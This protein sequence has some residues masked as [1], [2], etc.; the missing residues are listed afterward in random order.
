MARQ[1][2][3]GDFCADDSSSRRPF[4]R[5]AAVAACMPVARRRSNR[6]NRLRLRMRLTTLFART[7]PM[8]D[9]ARERGPPAEYFRIGPPSRRY[10]ASRAE[11]I[12]LR[13]IFFSG[14]SRSVF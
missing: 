7:V 14:W 1:I 4:V 11:V 2:S 12:A 3:A 9:T 5:R 8:S 6:S 10:P 13:D